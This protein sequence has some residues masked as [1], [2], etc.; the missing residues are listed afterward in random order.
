MGGDHPGRT[1]IS[2]SRKDGAEFAAWLRGWL[3]ERDLSVWQDILALEGGRDWWSQIEEAL[4][5]KALQHF[6]LVVT[7]ASLGSPVVR[8]EIRL[9]RQ[10]GKTACP[11]KGP[12]LGDL[13]KLPRW[14]GQIYDLDLT[15]HQTTLV[16][17]L[18]ADSRQKR[19]AMMAPE[20]PPDFVKRPK[21]F[22]ALKKQLLDAK[23][24]AIA[25]ITAALKG[26]G[27]YGKTTLAKA[28]A[29]DPDIQDAF[30]DGILW[31]ELGETPERLIATLSDLIAL[32]AGEPPGLETINAA[33]AKLGEALGDRRILL[34]VDDA[35]REPD[36]RPFLQGGPNCVRLVTTRI[37]SVLPAK[38]LRQPVDAMQAGEAL[39]LLSA[40]LPEDQVAGER[41]NLAKLAA[42]LGKWA[43]LLKIVNGFL[44]D[45]VVKA[46]ETLS[47]AIAGANKRLD[48]KGLSVFDPRDET[49]R[50]KA[51][52]RTI[53]V[54]LE[55]L[56]EAERARFG[57]LGV[58]PEDA[59]IPVGVIAR[60]WAA[61]G[62]LEDFETEDLLTRLFDLSLLHDFDLGQGYF[63]LHDTIRH[64]LRDR[65]GKER[66]IAQ[67]KALIAALEGA[68]NARADERT[69]R[70]FHRS[71]PHHLAEAGEREKLDALLLD[72]AWLKAKLEATGN[73]QLLIADY[74]LY[75]AGKA[76]DLISRTLP[77]ISDICARDPRQLPVQLAT[78]LTGFEEVAAT[79]FLAETRRLIS[80][81]AIIPL[82]PSS[83]A[84]G[85]RDGTSRGAFR[86]GRRPVPAAGRAARLGLL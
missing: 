1:F 50:T 57:E 11:V 35:W 37:D 58:F 61:T 53:S 41:A 79:G 7:P 44:R 76:Q 10:E 5:S 6:I 68:A 19:V 84:A 40:G 82:R 18:Q 85:G 13:G 3:N 4:K 45:R 73:T 81:P 71:L 74:K 33:A 12:G 60:L 48:A 21:E 72:P 39:S 2:Y 83:N 77:L 46:K 20:P 64:F 16:R 65:A 27:G 34:I 24:D 42:R 29:H 43:Q 28:L 31:A 55:L 80:R 75:G 36:L 69:R 22:D 23:G 17:V 51:V 32:L 26:A 25:G 66:L 52:A 86:R 63:R 8:R 14:L 54:S 62:S 30:F 15:E 9:A 59:D 47:A 38:A 56:S 70:Y 49:D 78:R 67:H